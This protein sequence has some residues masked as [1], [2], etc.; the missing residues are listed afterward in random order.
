MVIKTR[1]NTYNCHYH[2]V[3][4]TKY[5]KSIFETVSQQT[6]AISLFKNIASENDFSI[7]S[8]DV[9]PDHVHMLIS[10]APTYSISQVVKKIKGI[11]ARKWFIKHP[12]TKDQLWN[13]QLWSPSYYIGTLGNM[14]KKVVDDYINNQLTEYN[15]GRPRRDSSRS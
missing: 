2:L 13:G 5:R 7:Q 9:L 8:I 1:T 14:S 3:F 6:E 15:N 10:F 11:F 12:D 4:A